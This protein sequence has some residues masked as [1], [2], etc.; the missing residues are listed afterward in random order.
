[1]GDS[2]RLPVI[3]LVVWGLGLCVAVTILKDSWSFRISFEGDHLL[4]Q[5][6]LGITRLHYDNISEAKIIPAFGAGIALKDTSR[7][8]G[9]F[10]GKPSNLQKLRKVSGFTKGAYGCEVCI[11]KKRLDIGPEKFVQEVTAR[12]RT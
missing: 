2:L 11:T 10:E 4:M 5:D 9:T 3:A 8:L 6:N 12:I 1:L 7:W